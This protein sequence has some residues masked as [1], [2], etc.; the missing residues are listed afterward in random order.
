MFMM[1]RDFTLT[2]KEREALNA[3]STKIH[4][5]AKRRIYTQGEAGRYVY[6]IRSGAVRLE[7]QL[8]DG[9]NHIFAFI[10][11]DDMFGTIED[12][13]YPA[14]AIAL[15]DTYLFQ[16]PYS[17]LLNLIEIHPRIQT[18]FLQQALN[19]TRAAQRHLLLATYPLVLKRLAGF[20]L[21]C[22]KQADFYDRHSNILTLA[23]DRKDIAD[24]LGFAVE[25]TSRML[26]ELEDMRLIKRLSSQR[27]ILDRHKIMEIF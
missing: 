4:R 17:A 14:S 27:I 22:S 7:H 12:G 19:Y 23:M 18:L 8:N 6:R 1:F 24:Y 25:T 10:W 21:E 11:P 13:V 15:V 20:L 2:D 16:I 9:R 5:P 26:K 3:I